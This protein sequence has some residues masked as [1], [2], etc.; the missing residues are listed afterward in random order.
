MR[1]I[2]EF[3]RMEEYIKQNMQQYK[4]PQN[5]AEALREL[6]YTVEEKEK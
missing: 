1:Y 5:Y 4:L 3:N 2:N 6:A